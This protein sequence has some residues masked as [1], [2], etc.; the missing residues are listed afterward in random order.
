MTTPSTTTNPIL[1][2]TAAR[3][4]VPAA[5]PP[6]PVAENSIPRLRLALSA[7][8]GLGALDGAWWP[9]S[10]NLETELADLVDNFP[11]TSRRIVHAVYSAPDW[12]PAHRRIK[13]KQGVMKVGSFPNDDSHR[14]M[15]SMSSRE[16]LHLMVI[17][18]HS[19]P[20][21]ALSVMVTA[22][23]PGNR[24]SAATILQDAQQAEDDEDAAG[25]WSDDGGPWEPL[26]PPRV[27]HG[28]WRT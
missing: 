1:A 7:S 23:S 24:D 19:S 2:D 22:A 8:I 12:R 15:L 16:I 11:A 20:A 26:L 27:R 14:I 3:G 25:R 17:P 13:T 28:S 4:P 9:R 21:L 5:D 10:R 6:G 18:P